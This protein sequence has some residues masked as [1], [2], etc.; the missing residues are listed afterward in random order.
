MKIHDFGSKNMIPGSKNDFPG[1][2][3]NYYGDFGVKNT[4]YKK[5][6]FFP[7]LFFCIFD[8]EFDSNGSGA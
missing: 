5:F 6:V 3:T 7:I 1:Q 8:Q 4:F 2:K